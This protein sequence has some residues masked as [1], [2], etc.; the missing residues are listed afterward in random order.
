MLWSGVKPSLLMAVPSTAIYF[1]SY[2]VMRERLE[3]HFGEGSIGYSAAPLMAGGVARTC[4]AFLFSPLELVRT[5]MQAVKSSHTVL[6]ALRWEI[7]CGTIT[8]LCRRP[9][10]LG[11]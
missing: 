7:R 9:S 1:T 10:L 3:R 8:V 6:E 11:L 2:D 5:R 4:V